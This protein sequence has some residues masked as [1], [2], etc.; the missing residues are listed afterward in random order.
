MSEN[1]F[2][3]EMKDKGFV[4]LPDI[5][6]LS[7]IQQL[8]TETEAAL[9]QE[10]EY[11]GTENYYFYGSLLLAC[12]YGGAFL[13]LF[14]HESFLKPFED[15]LEDDCIVYAY[16]SSSLPPKQKIYTSRIHVD[17][18][19]IIKE[20]DTRIIGMVLL[21]DFTEDNGAPY[22]LASSFDIIEKP[23][24]DYFFKHATRVTGRA[25]SVLY[26]HPRIWHCAGENNTKDWRHSLIIGMTR[27]WIKQRF[28]IPR[29][30][31]HMDLSHLSEK[32]MEKFG[33]FSQAPVTY[34]EFHAT[35]D[36]R[37]FWK[38]KM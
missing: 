24:E 13:T 25:G 16:T 29:V 23:D 8:R 30:M 33:F 2:I 1:L 21:S 5:F 38:K 15:I 22:F 9:K 37:P 27:P 12:K 11:H 20:Y 32:S 18:S 4:L 28:D 3:K 19:L 17:S 35:K 34:D 36:R 6:P 14:E 31:E 26:F 10:I 7:Y